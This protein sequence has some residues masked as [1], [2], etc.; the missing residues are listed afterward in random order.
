MLAIVVH[1]GRSYVF[2]ASGTFF[3]DAQLAKADAIVVTDDVLK[4]GM[5]ISSI[6]L[7]L[8]NI[9][10]IVVTVPVDLMPLTSA[11][12]IEWQPSNMLANDVSFGM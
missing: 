12:L 11:L 7:Q 1:F 2:T 6:D 4:V 5:M 9:E 10:A 3:K 8:L